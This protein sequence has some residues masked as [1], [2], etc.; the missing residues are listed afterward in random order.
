MF[1]RNKVILLIFLLVG[2]GVLIYSYPL[3]TR[4]TTLAPLQQPAIRNIPLETEVP[5]DRLPQNFPEEV[6]VPADSKLIK[7]TNT[8]FP[9]GRLWATR[10]Y[11]TSASV[12]TLQKDY[13]AYLQS[14]EGWS[15]PELYARGK[16]DIYLSTQK[17]QDSLVI[18]LRRG[19]DK[20]LVDISL[21]TKK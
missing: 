13:E 7:N 18:Y 12:E 4:R 15:V 3:I 8:S 11:E 6:F 19:K 2:L 10:V 14:L 5:F 17:D 21:V 16:S 9:D 1:L 20:S